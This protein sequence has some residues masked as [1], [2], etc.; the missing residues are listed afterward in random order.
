MKRTNSILFFLLCFSISKSKGQ[1]RI[2]VNEYLNIGVGGRG[3][4]MAGAQAASTHDITSGY[5][6]PAGLMHITSDLE[7]GLMHA[8]Y[9][10]GNAKYDYGA[11]VK[12]LK[13]KKR[14]VGISFLRFAIDDIPNTID[15]VQPDGSFDESK[16]KSMSAADY[17]FLLSY[18]QGLK[19]FKNKN[20]Q[21]NIGGNAK[22]IYRNLG[23]MANAWGFGIDLGIQA[24]YKQWLFGIM[25]KDIT[26]TYTAWSFHLTDEEKRVFYQTGNDI[27]VK[28]YEVML[29]R[30]NFGIAR[31]FVKP[32]KSIQLLAEAGFDLTTDGHRNTLLASST[33][34]L[35]PRLGIEASYKNS[36]F[37]RAG[38]SNFQYVLDDKDTMN[39]KKR[40]IFQPSIG[41]GV[42]VSKLI[43]DYAFTSLQT[44]SN[45]LFTH[46]I[47]L[48][49]LLD[50]QELKK[51]K[52]KSASS[53]THH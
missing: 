36:I 12:P 32:G 26:T 23:T 51:Q 20:I 2:Y 17:A 6:N 10:S 33:F 47:S 3:L 50:N 8:E 7:I 18:A 45:P 16:L 52:N 34:S 11:I 15:Y 48:R 31:Q 53:R 25:A 39:Q 27:P 40:M 37:L 30:F 13:D 19:I 42:K 46:I 28:S 14:V 43:I 22:I 9:F 44:Q 5:W 1:S 4:A 38:V 41:L 21:T 35:D 29:P 24:R 49:V